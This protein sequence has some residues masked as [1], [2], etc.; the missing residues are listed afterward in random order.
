VDSNLNILS[1]ELF[2]DIDI[3]I[4]ESRKISLGFHSSR[5]CVYDELNACLKFGKDNPEVM[6][7][8]IDLIR[9]DGFPEN[10][11]LFE[12]NIIYREHHD[13]DVIKIMDEWWWWVKYYSRRDQLSFIYV[14]WKNK[15]RI[16]P[17]CDMPY[18]M[19]KKISLLHSNKHI[20][21][22]E[23]IRQKKMFAELFKKVKEK[24]S[25]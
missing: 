24:K 8:Q 21:K 3:A 16:S 18:R 6:K 1:N 15:F 23:L 9:K 13:K 7:A 22:E 4:K 14:L 17:L 11:G 25:E 2:N 12:N 20:T 5:N 10:Y 19:S